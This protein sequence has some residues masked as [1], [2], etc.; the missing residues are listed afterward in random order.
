MKLLQ[1]HFLSSSVTTIDKLFFKWSV[2]GLSLSNSVLN[3]FRIAS[4]DKRAYSDVDNMTKAAEARLISRPHD[5]VLD[6]MLLDGPA[7]RITCACVV[8]SNPTELVV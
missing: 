2:R 3:G 6:Q 4:K 7:K 1:S 8:S 5:A